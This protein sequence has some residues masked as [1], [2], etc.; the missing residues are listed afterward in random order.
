MA[1]LRELRAGRWD[2]V[3]LPDQV[4]HYPTMLT[5]GERRLLHWLARDVWEGWGAIVDAGCFLGGSTAALASGIQARSTPPEA[6]GPTP[7]MWT[8]DLFLADDFAIRS[9]HL[10]RWPDIQIDESFREAFDDLLGDLVL[11]TRVREGDIMA[12]QWDGGPIEILFLDVLK[13]SQINDTVLSR[14]L[15]SLVAG[16]SVIVQQDYVHGMLP[17]IHIT[18]EL[19]DD[20]VERI[21]D[22]VGTRVYAVTGEIDAERVAEILPLDERVP[23][24]R[25]Q[26]LMER[27]VGETWG[28]TRGMLLLAQAN[29]LHSHGQLATAGAILEH[30]EQ[31]YRD[32]HAVSY[33]AAET[34]RF[35]E[36]SGW[37]VAA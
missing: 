16:R 30:V 17:W 20:V 6:G 12:E 10:S 25:Q 5:H 9:G 37:P 24:D 27:V 35:L 15:P 36:R 3:V 11:H 22:E 29:L 8:Y 4:E 1:D 18:M 34:R 7:P 21:A 32:A 26:E 2:G 31:H 23:R 14:F 13:N 28:D 33:D 19:L